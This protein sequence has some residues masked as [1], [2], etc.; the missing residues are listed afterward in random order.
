MTPKVI[1]ASLLLCAL[2]LAGCTGGSDNDG[3]GTSTSTSG[4][5]GAGGCVTVGS[6]GGCSNATISGSATATSTSASNSTTN[7]TGN[8]TMQ[9]TVRIEGGAF[10]PGEVTV[11]VGG[12]VT[13]EHH[14]GTTAHT[15]T[16]DDGSFDS[17]PSCSAPPLPIS[18]CMEDGDTYPHTFA[19]AGDF[20]Y[21]DKLDPSLTGV[22]HVV[23]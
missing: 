5:A 10:V 19:A 2:A 15:V 23:A 7:S 18:D 1:L 20:G 12:T 13:W 4:G 21:H 22:V 9:Q 16:A 8:A 17:S 14:D 11:Q 6:S 3:G